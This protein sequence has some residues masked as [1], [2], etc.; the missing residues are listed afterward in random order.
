MKTGYPLFR[1][2][3]CGFP[4]SINLFMKWNSN[5]TITANQWVWGNDLRIL[6][7]RQGF[8][9][10]LFA[11]IE[12]HLGLSIEHIAFEAERQASMAVFKAFPDKVPGL[13]RLTRLKSVRKLWV[14][15]SDQI[16]AMLGMCSST[17]SEYV[18][19]KFSAG[20]IRN[21]F[22]LN[23]LGA[24]IA[25]DFELLEKKPLK[26]T[27]EQ[28][29]SNRYRILVELAAA[30]S[31][32]SDRMSP[33]IP[34][35]T[36]ML[37]PSRQKRS[38]GLL[39]GSYVHKRCPECKAPTAL[40]SLKWMEDE[41]VIMDTSNWVRFYIGDAYFIPAVF[42]ELASELGEDAFSIIIDS[43]KNYTVTNPSHFG[44]DPES[45]PR[46]RESL[47]NALQRYVSYLPLLGEGN[48]VY[49][50][51]SE[52]GLEVTIE[53]PYE[54]LVVA[55]TLQ[56]LFEWMTQSKSSLEWKVPTEG[57]LYCSIKSV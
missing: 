17:T 29:E 56:G 2:K 35:S 3:A 38:T 39:S 41:G 16:A 55:A 53:N 12:G 19:G 46:N 6:I 44:L 28:I 8:V 36:S 10:Q 4:R 31:S 9:N 49:L 20:E 15:A 52:A 13:D 18:P 11:H 43:V 34:G 57:R 23:L 26:V 22:N 14:L 47:K 40:S 25:G 33:D 37:F 24:L 30:R 45:R 32:I 1:C 42:R 7:L 48:P 21:P 54:P 50:N 5:G 51:I 27:W